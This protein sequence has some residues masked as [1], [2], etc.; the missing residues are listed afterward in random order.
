[1]NEDDL[2]VRVTE[3]TGLDPQEIR[4]LLSLPPEEQKAV[5][6]TYAGL[7]WAKSKD[8]LGAIISAFETAGAVAGAASAIVA[9]AALL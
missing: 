1:M 3:L 9:F 4:D 5:V 6:Q 8:T 2:V 7:D